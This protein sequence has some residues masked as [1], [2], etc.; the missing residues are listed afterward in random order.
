[1]KPRLQDDNSPNGTT[2]IDRITPIGG[3]AHSKKLDVS[4]GQKISTKL[5][6]EAVEEGKKRCGKF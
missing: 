3:V 4:K 1:M 2:F 6:D 5:H